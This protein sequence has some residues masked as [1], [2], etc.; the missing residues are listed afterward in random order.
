MTQDPLEYQ[1]L[2]DRLQVVEKE[3]E[4]LAERAEEIS[5]LGLVAEQLERERDPVELLT[6]VLER[7]CILKA[8]PYGACLERAGGRL[9]ATAVYHSR[10]AEGA[11]GADRF[12]VREPGAW[13]P[14]RAM[15]LDAGDCARMF[16][17]L[18]IAGPDLLPAA[19]A[20]IPLKQHRDSGCCLLFADARRGPGELEPMLPMLERVVDLVR[21]HLVK[22]ALISELRQLTGDLDLKVAE[23]TRELSRSEERYRILFEHVPDGILLVDADDEGR[24]GRIED[25]NAVAAALHGYSLEELRAMDLESLSATGPEL[26]SFEA[27]VWRL[28]QL[29]TVREELQHRRKDG[30]VFP[31][32][33][34]G[35]L[36][37]VQGHQYVLGFFRD[38]TERKRAE[39]ALLGAQRAESLGILAG[40]IAHDF[41]N[42]LTAIIGQICIALDRQG[43]HGAGR[44]NLVKALDASER[45]ASLTRQM[46][47]YSGRGKFSLQA[48]SINRLIRENAVILEAAVPKRVRLELD[49]E[50]GL[51]IVVADL[52][53][54]Q[55]VIMNLVI[56]GIE[57][58]GAA[59]GLVAVRTRAVRLG[60]ADCAMW[61]RSGPSLA[62]G[63]YVRI[64]VQDSGCGMAEAVRS[65][66]FEPFYSTKAKGHGLGLSA[67][68][69]II[70]GHRGGLGV[71]SVEG[72]GTTFRILLPVGLSAEPVAEPPRLA[73]HGV[74]PRVV[75]VID[76]ENYLLEVVRDSLEA[77]GHVAILA[78]SGEEG[79]E[80][81]SQQG[82]G[83]DLI[84]LDLS[85]PGLGG[86]ETFRRVRAMAP[87]IPVVL[88]SGFAE[89]ESVA[90]LK[91]MELAGFLQKP[92]R[93]RT[94]VALVESMP[95]AKDRKA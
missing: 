42:L 25:A 76:D 2:M 24:F 64:E 14:S 37:Q 43:P 6:S 31:V 16:E 26:E 21:A 63:D 50:Q 23:R 12:Q 87:A 89:E 88:T 41:N 8:I 56:N 93:A 34:I 74:G 70:R 47:A 62:P 92:Y 71:D 22:L 5:L 36:V 45:A 27:R 78:G 60:Q 35:T 68:Q 49:L 83:I 79:L 59:A 10:R 3:N 9:E 91:D 77:A 67:V 32:E 53:Q 20:L 38:L 69:G 54:L 29:D 7:V 51:P 58:I 19:V 1:D 66:I 11:D 48:V 94:L 85:M 30:S 33:A 18:E 90:Q 86:V 61:P 28:R 65:R 15:V 75:L 57:A 81:V 73:A 40:G 84:L 46:L 4:L 55:Q 80:R 82:D 52:S 13:P 44:E 95:A 39:E 72:S 17:H